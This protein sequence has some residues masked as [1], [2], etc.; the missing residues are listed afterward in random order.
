MVKWVLQVLFA[1]G[2]VF[3]I[4]I[5]LI[6]YLFSIKKYPSSSLPHKEHWIHKGLFN[7]KTVFENTLPA[8]DSAHGQHI[9]GLEMD[10]YYI[11]S[12]NDFIVTHDLPNRYHLPALKLSEVLSRYD[13]AFSYWLDLKNLTDENKEPISLRFKSMLSPAMTAKVYI[14]SG[15]APELGY[16]AAQKLK[17]IY[18]IQYNRTNIFKK[19]IKQT[20]IKWQFIQYPFEGATIGAS[21]TDDNFFETFQPVPKFIFHIYTPELYGKVQQ[22]GNIAVYLMDYMPAE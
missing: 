6:H 15:N 13:T 2:L 14:E 4:F 11:D 9:Q 21:M 22:Q 20:L 7:N 18:W 19:W 17:T 5:G 16:L 12:L 8:F 3:C 1:I 10:V